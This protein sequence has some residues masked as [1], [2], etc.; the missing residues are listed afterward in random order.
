M[1]EHA[2]SPEDPVVSAIFIKLEVGGQH[3]LFVLLAAD[4]SINRRGS[5]APWDDDGH[6]YIGITEAGLFKSLASTVNPGWFKL[7]SQRFT[8]PDPR[9]ALCLLT[10][11]LT[12]GVGERIFEFE[13]GS[14]SQG[15]P[16]D[17]AQLVSS[18]VV[19]TEPWYESSKQLTS[20]AKPWWKF[21]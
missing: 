4:G 10:V 7:S 14:D 13:Y 3:S 19:L 21:W 11:G 20:K 12:T 8:M 5:G 2:S 16:P 18:A 15:P 6:L 17:I 9:G 1:S